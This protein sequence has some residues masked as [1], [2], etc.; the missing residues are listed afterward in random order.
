M[1]GQAFTTAAGSRALC[2][3]AWLVWIA[4]LNTARIFPILR[5]SRT[6]K[7]GGP[8]SNSKRCHLAEAAR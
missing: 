1:H 6:M 5:L 7:G 8:V 3:I 2:E 4:P